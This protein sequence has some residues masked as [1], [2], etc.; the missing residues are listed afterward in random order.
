M[1][2]YTTPKNL[3]DI[4]RGL[5][6]VGGP[7][8]E[9]NNFVSETL[10]YV[11][12]NQGIDIEYKNRFYGD[13]VDSSALE[14]LDPPPLPI[15]LQSGEE[16]EDRDKRK[17]LGTFPI[18]NRGFWED[19]NFDKSTLQPYLTNDLRKVVDTRIV[20]IPDGDGTM[21]YKDILPG[22]TSRE[23][24][25]DALVF[26]TD[27]N[28]ENEIIR[29]DRYYDKELHTNEYYLATEGKI[30]YYLYPRT[31]GRFK[32]DFALDVYKP[33]GRKVVSSAGISHQ[34]DRSAAHDDDNEVV[35]RNRG[36]FLFDLDW[37]DGTPNEH[38]QKPKLLESSVILDHTYE[39]P[40]F[41]TITGTVFKSNGYKIDQYE[42]FETRILLNPSKT[43]EEE[44]NLLRNQNFA[45]IGGISTDS[46]LVKSII[47]M[48]GVD[49]FDL[50]DDR[51]EESILENYNEL[52]NIELLNFMNMVNSNV[53][54]KYQE[55]YINPYSAIIDD[56]P[57]PV[58]DIPQVFGC[59]DINSDNYAPYATISEGCIYSFLIEGSI[60][61]LGGKTPLFFIGAIHRSS[62]GNPN[63][64][65]DRYYLRGAAYEDWNV[66]R[67]TINSSM[68]LEDNFVIAIAPSSLYPGLAISDETPF[69][70]WTIP[71]GILVGNVNTTDAGVP[72]IEQ[73]S[74]NDAIPA[75]LAGQ[76]FSYEVNVP[77]NPYEN[78]STPLNKR[79]YLLGIDPDNPPSETNYENK[80]VIANW[81]G[82]E[83]DIGTIN[84]GEQLFY[85]PITLEDVIG[86]GDIYISTLP[87]SGQD[88]F[89][90][91]DVVSIGIV[92]IAGGVT[93][94]HFMY[95]DEEILPGDSRLG[96]I[97]GGAPQYTL[98][99]NFGVDTQYSFTF[100][101]GEVNV[102]SAIFEEQSAVE[103]IIE[104]DGEGS[105]EYEESDLTV[106]RLFPL[107]V[108]SNVAAS[109][110]K[111]T[112]P[113]DIPVNGYFTSNDINQSPYYNDY[114]SYEI[115]TGG[116]IYFTNSFANDPVT[117]NTFKGWYTKHPFL[118]PAF[119]EDLHLLTREKNAN[120]VAQPD[121]QGN[122]DFY[123]WSVS[124]Q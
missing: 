18:S 21:V 39:K 4:I 9:G 88:G 119:D 11:K 34:F 77:Q 86:D 61:G 15:R 115:L 91:G 53:V 25:M 41:Y 52:D 101:V 114:I 68:L 111:F 103:E 110:V 57:T 46:S 13:G 116:S 55:K 83:E 120:V 49:P 63:V 5:Q 7:P 47:S 76:G 58:L 48:L 117:G 87:A 44:L 2:K 14:Q 100:T 33:R 29:V 109:E 28:N 105:G 124:G 50:D 78:V 22:Q 85:I 118:D 104:G 43:K 72:I 75:S 107:P 69:D 24:S 82:E 23:Y 35:Y 93:L 95:N 113:Q 38:N 20:A 6:S 54:N 19:I 67:D 106:V 42:R 108:G 112:N 99:D 122:Q 84:F 98:D 3:W 66:L 102:I 64:D 59:M 12:P 45:T 40:G 71:D 31:S 36:Y 56:E 79:V 51:A 16:V 92:P 97:V 26:V 17:S 70:G 8:Y 27:P 65:K 1:P 90:L 81:S 74:G 96:D 73:V 80:S 60:N 10:R 123:A 62:T 94:Q 89:L 121:S 32:P 37:G 30:N